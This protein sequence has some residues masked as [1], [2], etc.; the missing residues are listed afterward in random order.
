[1]R[2]LMTILEGVEEKVFGEPHLVYNDR[3]GVFNFYGF[4]VW[5]ELTGVK[6]RYAWIESFSS[7]APGQGNGRKAIKWLTNYFKRIGVNDPGVPDENPDSFAFWKKL[8]AEGLIAQMQAEAGGI[9]YDNGEWKIRASDA[10]AYAPG[11]PEGI[12]NLIDEEVRATVQGP[13]WYEAGH[14][15]NV[16]KECPDAEFIL[17]GA[18][19]DFEWRMCQV[20]AHALEHITGS[21]WDRFFSGFARWGEPEEAA[22]FKKIEQWM[23]PNPIGRLHQRP[24]IILISPTTG[25][26]RILDG[27]HR[28][29]LAIHK[30]DITTIPAVV[31]IGDPDA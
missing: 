5:A 24:P 12:P 2:D 16:M 17:E 19:W 20:P 10:E 28:A 15:V 9:I 30:F 23:R 6:K 25:D 22:R 7:A 1:M 8:C 27:N 3:E 18:E 29:G 11:F 14:R 4:G 26:V 13:A 21:D 31:A